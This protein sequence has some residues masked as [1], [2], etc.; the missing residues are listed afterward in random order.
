MKS[1]SEIKIKI[2]LTE[3]GEIHS[4]QLFEGEPLSKLEFAGFIG[5]LS[6]ILD[7]IKETFREEFITIK[8]DTRRS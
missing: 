8:N 7:S 2:V 5:E 3:N 6:A 4:G 1:K